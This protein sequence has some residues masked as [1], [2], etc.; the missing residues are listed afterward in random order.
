M[1]GSVRDVL[2]RIL[3]LM[4]R[5]RGSEVGGAR[6]MLARG[7]AGAA[8]SLSRGRAGAGAVYTSPLI[9]SRDIIKTPDND[10]FADSPSPSPSAPRQDGKGL[11]T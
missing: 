2:V 10:W 5:F 9:V 6:G 4:R 7:R 1:A 11:T 8:V 3:R